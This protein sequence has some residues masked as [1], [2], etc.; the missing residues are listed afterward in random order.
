MGRLGYLVLVVLLVVG[1]AYVFWPEPA[2][3]DEVPLWDK[4]APERY[5][6][7]SGGL[8]QEVDAGVVRIQG[9]ERPLD[10]D[11]HRSLW[12][13]LA[14]L[15]FGDYATTGVGEDQLAD[16]G[17][18]ASRELSTD[19]LRLRWG[20][21]AQDRYL[22]QAASGRLMPCQPVIIDRLDALTRRLDRQQLVDLPAITAIGI[23]GLRL[24]LEG[25]TWS[26]ALQAERPPFNRRVNRLF[27]L[28][29]VL[30][31]DDFSRRE[32]PPAPPLHQLRFDS[33]AGAQHLRLWR[34]D[35][36]GGLAQIDSLPVQRL[37]GTTLAL[38][39]TRVAEFASDFLFNLEQEFALRPLAEI[40]LRVGTEERFRLEKH[41]LNDVAE[42][43]SQWDVVWP[44]GRE[45]AGSEAAGA[46]AMALDN[47]EVR[48]PRRRQA[49]EEPPAD[50][51]RL[52]FT[53]QVDRRTIEI[54]FA[55]DQVYS[56]THVGTV[57]AMPP[58]LADLTP[59]RMLDNALTLRGAE[60]VVKIQRQWHRGPQAGRSEVVAVP[61]GTGDADGEWRQTWPADAAGAAVSAPAVDRLARA[62]C[63]ARSRA[64]RLATAAD[65]AALAAPEFELDLRFAQAQVRLSNDHTRLADTTDQDLGFAFVREGDAWRAIDKE[66]GVSHLVDADLV[67]LL[68][69]PL[70]DDLV[71][72]LVPSL[73]GRLEINGPQGRFRVEARGDRWQLQDLDAGGRPVG[74]V[75]PAD[76]VE[77]RRYLRL[78]AGLRAQRREPDAGPFAATQLAGSVLCVLPG[79][80]RGDARVVLSIGQPI[81]DLVPLI[82][83]SGSGMRGLP[84]GRALLPS[85][86]A[87][88]L[89]PPPTRFRPAAAGTVAP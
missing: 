29:E 44:G 87:A 14:N 83:E 32:A 8:E 85:A 22:W 61:S 26:D 65:R 40:H 28:V 31:I 57:V 5:R 68:Q 78:L 53:F 74:A 55:G 18:D 62:L 2:P 77:V 58:L 46:I 39:R 88:D 52:R 71:L 70:G 7:V 67:E 81:G 47:L 54:A 21:K 60:R 64:V 6:V 41:G 79:A 59:D 9:V 23:D 12:S 16:Y 73:V 34:T 43:R 45:P 51:Q 38:W 36:D 89:L 37:N 33:A 86:Q 80:D 63:T 30:R 75:Q 27:D 19:G 56:A 48:A 35:D 13:Y 3:T 69:A 20:G 25:G 10:D 24:R 50:A 66:G 4:P 15:N 72:P 11:R 49:G 42:G 84:R 82:V 76:A 17:L 1:G